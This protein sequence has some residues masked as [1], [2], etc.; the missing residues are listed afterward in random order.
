MFKQLIRK[1]ADL[2]GELAEKFQD[3]TGTDRSCFMTHAFLLLPF[4][5]KSF[6]FV[7]R[8]YTLIPFS[9]HAVFRQAAGDAS[10]PEE[11]ASSLEKDASNLEEDASTLEEDASTLEENASSPEEDASGFEE[12]A[13]SLEE[14]ASSLEG[15]ASGFEEG[16]AP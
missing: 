6:R 10:I 8:P 9:E 12:D 15:D 3:K 14:D 16:A 7:C 2:L 1:A 11:D 4:F 13:S 5:L